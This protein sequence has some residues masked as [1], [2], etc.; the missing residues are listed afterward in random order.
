MVLLWLE[1]CST[2]ATAETATFSALPER[3]VVGVLAGDEPLEGVQDGRLTGFSG[4]LLRQLLANTGTRLE[5]RSFRHRDEVMRAACAGQVDLVMVA[6]SRPEYAHCLVYSTAYLERTALLVTRQE[7]DPAPTAEFFRHATIIVVA[8]SPWGPELQE[9]YPGVRLI[10]VESVA[11]GLEALAAGHGDAYIGT[12][13]QLGP[14]LH[15]PRFAMLHGLR[16]IELGDSVFRFAAPVAFAQVPLELDRRLALLPDAVFETLRSKWLHGNGAPSGLVFLLSPTEQDELLTHRTIRYT[17]PVKQPPFASQDTRGVL[18]GLTVDYLE[19]LG[20]RLDIEFT[21]VPT[22]DA[23]EAQ[24]L[25][26]RGD[27]DMIAGSFVKKTSAAPLLSAGVYESVP[28]VIVTSTHSPYASNLEGIL[29]KKVAVVKDDPMED[30]I[31]A[32]LPKSQLVEVDSAQKGLE[33]VRTNGADAMLGNLTVMDALV[34]GQY[35][36]DL[37]ITGAA[38]FD[39]EFGL[40]MPVNLEPLNQIFERAIDTMPELE[41][42]KIQRRWALVD[43]QFDTP[44]TTLL[45]RLWP[46][47]LMA[48][49]ALLLA[50]SHW[51]LRHEMQRR[52][53]TENRLEHE[54]ALK[55]ALLTSLPEPIAAKDTQRRYLEFN[56]AF[57]RFFGVPRD[58]VLGRTSEVLSAG[59]PASIEAVTRLQDEALEAMAAR[60][61]QVPVFNAQGELRTVIFWA[62]PYRSPDGS[63]GGIVLTHTD[64]TDIH[65]AQQRAQMVEQR[66][67][68]VTQSL[69]A[70]VFQMRR[71]SVRKSAWD[72]T[73]IAGNGLG[74]SG[75]DT[76]FLR[77]KA[78]LANTALERDELLRLLKVLD[79]EEGASEPIEME[80]RLA[81]SLDSRWIQLRA[82]PRQEGEDQV[83]NGVIFDVTERH[84][85]ADALNEAKEVAEGALRAK[86]GF[87]AMMSHEIR[88]PMNG[89]LGLVEL[90]QN[91][92]LAPE[93]Q[94]MLALAKE[95]GQALAQILDDILDYAK[96][97]AGH[98]TI[99]PTP[100]DLRELFDSVLSLLLPLAHEKG[101]EVRQIVSA[102]VPATVYA[103]GIRVRQILFNLFGNA[104]KFTD[105]GSVTLQADV[106]LL[107]TGGTMVVVMVRDTGIGISKDDI[108][109][110]FAPFVQS[111]SSRGLGG[112]GLGLSISRRLAEMMGGQLTLESEEGVG[113]TTW[114]RVPC[115]TLH[116]DY[117]LPHLTARTAMLH[118]RNADSAISLA[119]YARAAGMRVLARQNDVAPVGAIH[120]V[121]MEHPE[122]AGTARRVIQVSTVSKQLGYRIEDGVIRLSINPLRWTAFLAATKAVLG[123]PEATPRLRVAAPG[124]AHAVPRKVLVAEDHPINR[125]VIKQQLELL[126]Y[127][128]T[129]VENGE[130]ALRELERDRFEMIITDCHMPIID[131]FDLTRAIRAHPRTDL[132]DLPVV[133]VTATTVREEH[134]RCVEVGMNS[135]VLKPVTLASLQK[136]LAAADDRQHAPAVATAELVTG[137]SAEA[138]VEGFDPTRINDDAILATLGDWS[139]RA[140]AQQLYQQA[141]HD[142]REALRACL[143]SGSAAD[144][145]KWCHRSS[146][147][148]SLFDQPYIDQTM[149]SFHGVA[150]SAQAPAVA[151]AAVDILAL[152]D[153]L[154][155][156]LEKAVTKHP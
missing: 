31:R 136:A 81:P 104:I 41:R 27:L 5:T 151:A 132:R 66:L 150:K 45:A 46:L 149:D 116:A 1:G 79:Q 64:I 106:E 128:T 144:L 91:T 18:S 65:A 10:D 16:R 145:L 9:T 32:R 78:S 48:L 42:G 44:W 80:L 95:S 38:G 19:Y 126:G 21:Y 43:Y 24:T 148:L 8:G 105:R 133:G 113:T 118:V 88:T 90:L 57:E 72:I 14:V 39:E 15:E 35:G 75:G 156:I 114:L 55:E 109:R 107:A 121:D 124:A 154:S 142:D 103:D 53:Q 84:V 71:A 123:E 77:G 22:R 40:W 115:S 49:V 137:D 92:P 73:Y 85:Q 87:L 139:V 11:L 122:D 82:V 76:Q 13:A 61:I 155:A 125:E 17:V 83:W 98:L 101:L 62:V 89:V 153:R 143:A 37:R 140:Q 152:Y 67:T 127:A 25:L 7:S 12:T 3:L 147:A 112:T 68:D 130:E 63:Q 54:L 100:L 119:S 50:V 129:L 102:E 141:L 29:G 51:R 120:F 34:R 28:M 47:L 86:E 117:A 6:V 96:I 108:Q 52:R 97:E 146:G 131:G 20:R 69:P 99:A 33:L 56:P 135:Y 58:Q 4:E 60:H 94:R 59:P 138:V 36:S 93:Q 30:L 26:A 70:L 110:L 111:E 2:C 74:L 23:T 134:L